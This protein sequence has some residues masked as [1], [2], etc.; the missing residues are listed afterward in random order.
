MMTP[1]W[2]IGL[3]LAAIFFAGGVSGWVLSAKR[4]RQEVFSPPPFERFSSSLRNRLHARLNL[5][6]SQ[7]VRIDAIIDKSSREMQTIHTDC[8]RKFRQALVNRNAQIAA[9][10]S[11][12]QQRQFQ[13]MERE[14]RES[15][16]RNHDHRH[17]PREGSNAPSSTTL[18]ASTN[19]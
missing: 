10:L 11:A 7:G 6:S 16:T 1:K 9:V 15:R 19:R 17:G 2:K 3:Y 5:T 13:Q 12:E 4:A 14:P 18:G 8:Q